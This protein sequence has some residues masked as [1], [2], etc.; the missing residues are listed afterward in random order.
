[1]TTACGGVG[2]GEDLSTRELSPPLLMDHAYEYLSRTTPTNIYLMACSRHTRGREPK[3]RPP[4]ASVAKKLKMRL[5]SFQ[6]PRKLTFL[7][8]RKDDKGL[9]QRPVHGEVL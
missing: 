8:T 1:V 4:F 2:E 6:I 5:T 7:C 3:G 9:R